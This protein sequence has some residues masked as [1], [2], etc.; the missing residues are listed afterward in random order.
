MRTRCAAL[1][2]SEIP[3]QPP[4]HLRILLVGLLCGCTDL[5]CPQKPSVPSTVNVNCVKIFGSR[6]MCIANDHPGMVCKDPLQAA[7]VV[8]LLGV[9][10]LQSFVVVL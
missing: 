10:C 4:Q 6:T 2:L 3:L 1:I 9:L 8:A 7:L 5:V